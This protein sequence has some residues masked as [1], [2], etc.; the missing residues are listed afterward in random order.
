[1]SYR[2]RSQA[3]RLVALLS[4]L[5]VILA[6]AAPSGGDT[7]TFQNGVSPDSNY[8]GCQDNWIFEWQPTNN[9]GTNTYGNGMGFYSDT[10]RSLI[11]F[12]VSDVPS[13]AIVTSAVLRL[14]M[15]K[16]SADRT[17]QAYQVLQPWTQMGST[18]EIYDTGSDWNSDGCDGVGTDHASALAGSLAVTTAD[19]DDWIEI[20]LDASLVQGWVDGTITNNGVLLKVDNETSGE[21]RFQ[22][23]NYST[24]TLR[25][26]LVIEYS[27]TVTTTFQNG[28]SPDSNYAGCEDNWIFSWQPTLNEGTNTYGNGIGFYSGIKRTPIKFDI[29]SISSSDTVSSA[30]LRL[31]MYTI[32][33]DRTVEAYQ[34]LQPWTQMGSTWNNYDANN[35]WDTAGC[36][37]SGTDRAS[38]ATGSVAVTTSQAGTWIEID[39]DT[40]L[41]QGWVDGTITNNGVLLK[42]TNEQS[43]E[44]RYRAE[45]Y[46]TASDRPELVIEHSA[47]GGGGDTTAPAAV[48]DLATTNPTTTSIDLTWTAPGDDGNTGTA[49]SYDIRYSTSTID[50]N[51]WASATLVTNEPTPSAA[52]NTD[53]VTVSGLTSGTTYYFAIKTSDEVPNVSALSNCES[54]TTATPDTTAPAAVADLATSNPSGS[55]IALTWTAPGDDG[56]T[57]TATSYDIRYSTSTIDENNW[58]SA[59][60]VSNEP[61]PS[62]AGNTD[63]VT[64]SGLTSDTTY[65]FAMK[66]SD[67]VPNVSALSNCVPGTTLD[68]TAPTA[69]SNL[70]AVSPTTTGITLTWTAPGDDG[71]TGTATSYDIRYSTST[72]NE[73]NWASTTSVS[74]PPTPSA[75]GNT[76]TVDVSGL[77]PGT[78]YYFAMKTSDEVPNI[79]ALSNVASETTVAADITA[80]AAVTDLAVGNPSETSLT[81]TWTAPGDD[82]STG[83]ATSYDIRYSTSTID[84]SNWAS[85]TPVTNEPTPSAANS[86][87]SMTVSGLTSGTTYYFALKTSDEVPN[88]SALSNVPSETT[89]AVPVDRTFQNGVSPDGSYAGCEDTWVWAYLPTGNFGDNTYGNGMGYY[90]SNIKRSLIKFD[91]SSIPT[92]ATVNSAT[93]ELYISKVDT[94][95]TVEAYQV[96]QPWTRYGSTWITYDGTNAWNTA[97]CGG[98]GTDHASTAAASLAVTT[99]DLNSSITITLPTSLVEGWIANSSTNNGL[100]LKVTDETSG[101]IRFAPENDSTAANRPKLVINYTASGTDVTPPATVSDLTKGTVTS[102]SVALSWTAPGDDGTSGTASVYDVR[103]STNP[104]NESNWASATPATGEPT[105]AIANSTENFTVSNLTPQTTYYFAMKTS[106]EVPNSS[107]LSNVVSATTP[108]ANDVTPPGRITSLACGSAT[109]SSVTLTWNAPGDDDNTGTA[110]SYEVR[111]A[112]GVINEANWGAA[113]SVTT[114]VPTPAAAGTPE[115]MEVTGLAPETTYYFAIK[116]SDEIPNVSLVSNSAGKQTLAGSGGNGTAMIVEEHNGIARSGEVLSG[117]VPFAVGHLTSTSGLCIKDGS[118]NPVPAQFSV[119]NRWWSPNYDDSIKWLQVVFPA[120]VAANGNSTYY[121]TTGTNP[122]PTDP[123]SL[124]VNGDVYTVTTGPIKAVINAAA[125]KLFDEVYY[126]ADDDG[127]YET[128]EKIISAST[129]DGFVITSG[130]WSALGISAGDQFRSSVDNATVTV[131]ENGPVRVVLC[132]EGIFQRSGQAA[133]DSYYGYQVRLYFTAGSAMVRCNA[134]LKNNRIVDDTVY[135]WPIEDMSL[136]STLALTGTKSDKML[137]QGTPVSGT[138]GANVVKVY[139]D[140]NGTDEWQTTLG[141]A[142]PGVTFRGYKMY[143]GTTVKETNNQARGWMELNNG[144]L[145]VA[146]GVREFWQQYPKAMRIDVN[147]LQVALLPGEFSEV[148]SLYD[149]SQKRHDVIYDFHAGALTDQQ[150]TND[151]L[152]G[153]RPLHMRCTPSTY[154]TS[155]AWDLGLGLAPAPSPLNYDRYATT[156]TNI[157]DKL[158]WKWFGGKYTSWNAGGLHQNQGS[159]FMAYVLWGD[160]RY[161]ERSEDRTLWTADLVPGIAYDDVDWNSHAET[162]YLYVLRT[163]QYVTALRYPGWYDWQRGSGYWGRPDPGHC[164]MLQNL[165]YWYLTGDRHA[166]EA[167]LYYGQ[168]GRGYYAPE[169]E[170]DPPEPYSPYDGDVDDPDFMVSNRYWSW[171]TF[172]LVQAYEASGDDSWLDDARIAVKGSRNALRISPLKFTDIYVDQLGGD[173]TES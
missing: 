62:A 137:G 148:S 106:D 45:N 101:E 83:T 18:W 125:F 71:S 111:Y 10:K 157:G 167:C 129:D 98:S 2:K 155:N 96:L 80:P 31:M 70:A 153:E 46:T 42:A 4:P 150:V 109:A 49:S 51:N 121:L 79:S 24:S 89:V 102:S 52:G 168:L 108:E 154:I 44:M 120:D 3:T 84:E 170:W 55:S 117:G 30:K 66:T 95:R 72:I 82:G 151:Y 67:E 145:G 22:P 139:Q 47:G 77:T 5:A 144:T 158:G 138:V 37:G 160:W 149:G 58:A 140:S 76:D 147:Q 48:T 57:G 27:T 143:D 141:E 32:G 94:N 131:E 68:V 9:Y 39:L 75:A 156:G 107:G 54:G 99:S 113:T 1:M 130:A 123:A 133:L 19:E 100:L 161:F 34:I 13:E 53:T 56:S 172:N 40:S 43:G 105:P 114:G 136:R 164:G 142:I 166:Y 119:L 8:S 14:Y 23:E 33:A 112:M 169:F 36:D 87:E 38:T 127:Q 165:E 65:Y 132:I 64:V 104:I 92:I 152:L 163:D 88:V 103:Y 78:T 6:F 135:S 20:S 122:T 25:P 60:P 115:S 173:S 28:V 146:A 81:L 118:G 134:T 69:V 85:A 50:E 7:I 12:D 93:L 159:M 21:M 128:G 86:N 16:V 90:N 124:T 110:A 17:V 91:L 74:N 11:K 35:A 126:D 171:S 73:G 116:T 26:Q 162:Q 15:S 63:T 59:T 41:V 97:G 29:S 61:T